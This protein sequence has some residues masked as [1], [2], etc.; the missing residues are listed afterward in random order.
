MIIIDIDEEYGFRNWVAELTEEEYQQLLARWAT[1]KGLNCLVPIPFII[2]Q[3]KRVE[4]GA[5]LPEGALSCHIHE[6]DDSWLEGAGRGV[7]VTKDH[8]FWMDGICYSYETVKKMYDK[9]NTDQT[10]LNPLV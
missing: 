4:D 9:W 3:A 8:S 10:V 5:P 2:P 7:P 1:I 6:C